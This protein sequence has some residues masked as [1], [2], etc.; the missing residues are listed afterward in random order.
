V[1]EVGIGINRK[2]L[3][4]SAS[5][6]VNDDLRLR[7]EYLVA[8]NRILRKQIAGRGSSGIPEGYSSP[9]DPRW[10]DATSAPAQWA[11]G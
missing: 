1:T 2:N 7:S 6:S 3:L 10:A 9:F 4:A 11:T 8:E 5:R